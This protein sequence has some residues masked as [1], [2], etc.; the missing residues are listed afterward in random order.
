M[1]QDEINIALHTGR[2]NLPV[3]ARR[4]SNVSCLG[5]SELLSGQ[6]SSGSEAP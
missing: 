3:E 4:M 5:I 1:T 6:L 2:T